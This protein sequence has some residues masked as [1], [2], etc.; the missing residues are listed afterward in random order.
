M[1]IPKEVQR[2][3]D[4]FDQHLKAYRSS[5]YNEA[6]LRNEF[7]NPFFKVLGMKLFDGQ[8]Q[9]DPLPDHRM[10]RQEGVKPTL[11]TKK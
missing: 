1:S 8:A 5:Q 10:R 9:G 2:L 3:I 4:R 7:L 11:F 6:Q